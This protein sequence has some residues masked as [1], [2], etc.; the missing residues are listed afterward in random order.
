MRF[1]GEELARAHATRA[2]DIGC[3]AARN[4]VPLAR[5]GWRVLG[6][7]LSLPMLQAA[8]ERVHAE[9][10]CEH[11]LDLALAPMDHLPVADGCCA[12]VIAHGIW[13]LAQ[14]S[15]EFRRAVREAARVAAHGAALF[16]FT[17]SR[18]T[19][20]PDAA[21]VEGEPFVFTQFSGAPQC[22][23]TEQQLVSELQAAGFVRDESVPLRELTRPRAGAVAAR[24]APV[25]YEGLFR[26]VNAAV[27]EQP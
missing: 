20:P 5:Q 12:F 26:R 22:F 13:N 6:L 4:A 10:G 2:L 14:S 17:F 21:P 19:L 11:R 24:R 15:A 16:V 7:D 1:A 3:G 25:I 9:L 18:N 8:R 23:L 27:R